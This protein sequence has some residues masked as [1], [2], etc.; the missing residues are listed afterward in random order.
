LT[1]PSLILQGDKDLQVQVADA[2]RLANASPKANLHVIPTM[3]HLFK[4]VVSDNPQENL[5]TYGDPSKPVMP[6]LIQ[7][8]VAFIR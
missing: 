4:A 3:N 2:E 7:Y 1:I 6:A 8:L 5:A